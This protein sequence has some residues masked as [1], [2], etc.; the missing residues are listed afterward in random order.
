MMSFVK[1]LLEIRNAEDRINSPTVFSGFLSQNRLGFSAEGLPEAG[2]RISLWLTNPARG[3]RGGSSTPAPA[4][5]YSLFPF[6]CFPVSCFPGQGRLT[7]RTGC[8]NFKR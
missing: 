1:S 5:I 3:Q 6:P 7:N 8:C 4:G 2:K